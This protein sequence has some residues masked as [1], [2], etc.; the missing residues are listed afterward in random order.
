M[1]GSGLEAATAQLDVATGLVVG[2][3]FE[4]PTFTA[5]LPVV[6][7]PVGPNPDR[8][9][10]RL[11]KH[12]VSRS[13]PSVSASGC[14]GRHQDSLLPA[15]VSYGGRILYLDEYVHVLSSET[16]H[17]CAVSPV[18]ARCGRRRSA[19]PCSAA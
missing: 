13:G 15:Q 2:E 4:F 18:R 8:P 9:T 1:I 11:M 16:P 5:D 7:C 10:A 3:R 6:L 14:C 17:T 19:R 12:H